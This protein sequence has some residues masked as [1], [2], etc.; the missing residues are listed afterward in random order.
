M[1]T[2]YS[3]NRSAFTLVELLVVIAI[4]GILIGMLLPAVQSVR[5]AARRTTCLNNLRQMG[6][7]IL[8]FESARGL[9]PSAGQ[10]RNPAGT[11]N[12]FITDDGVQ[13]PTTPDPTIGASHSV[14]TSLLPYIEQNTLY[15]LMDLSRAYNDPAAPGNL[16]AARNPLPV[17][18]CPSEG[19]RNAI[20]DADGFGYTDYSPPCT[21]VVNENTPRNGIPDSNN[22]VLPRGSRLPCAL[23][24]SGLRTIASIRDGTSNTIAIAEMAGRGDY[25]PPSPKTIND[26]NPN[27]RRFWA[28]AEPDNGYNVDQLINNNKTPT[29][30]PPEAPW[31]LL[32]CGPNEETFSFHPNGANVVLVDGSVHFLNETMDGGTFRA[33]LSIDG[34]EVVLDVF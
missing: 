19:Y 12:I 26:L 16:I 8:N 3:Q 13:E 4:I 32:N 9:L 20:Q 31:T 1:H 25:M 2:R 23:L 27:G 24:G 33:I 21:V 30:G 17:F 34:R 10:A 18:L 29:G 14:Q 6:I 15:Q 28:W 22:A 5:E 7:G 11:A